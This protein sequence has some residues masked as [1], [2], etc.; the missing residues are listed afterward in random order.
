MNHSIAHAMLFS[1]ILGGATALAQEFPFQHT[2]EVYRSDEDETIA[3]SLRL[4]QPFLAE[5]FEKSNYL[6]LRSSDPN[7]YLIY[8][9]ETKFYQ[10]HAEF[11]GRLKGS[12]KV[13][14]QLSYE[15]VSEN[16]DGSRRVQVREGAITLAIPD[17]PADRKSVG[18]RSIFED[19]AR[20]QNEHFAR[21]LTYY[22]DESF[23]QYCLLQSKARY[24][25]D[26][27]A[28][29]KR[30]PTQDNL[31]DGLYK[32]FTG[33]LAIQESLQR[34]TLS[35]SASRG[36][37]TRHISE[38]SPPR[39]RSLD[40]EELLKQRLDKEKDVTVQV[41]E[42][43]KLVPSDQ[44]FL[45]FNSFASLGEA[46]DLATQWGDD[47]VRLSKLTAQDNRL[48]AKLEE[49]L[50]IS[51]SGMEELFAQSVATEVA[52]TGSDPY[53]LDG[54]DVTV[55]I[56][57]KD[58]QAFAKQ[59]NSWVDEERGR[60]PDLVQRDFNYRGHQ[61]TARYTSDRLVSA[62]TTRHDDYYVFSN[63][64]RAIRRIVDASLGEVDRLHDAADYRYISTLMP[65]STDANSG[66]YFASDAFIRRIVA[67][68]AKISQKRRVECFNNLVMQNN[69]SL[70]FRLEYG[71]SPNSLSEMI[72]KRFIAADRITCPH[73]GA[74]AFDANSD[75]CT[76]SLHNR[77]RYLTPNAELSVLK[78]SDEE[79]AEYG[80]YKTRYQSFW[81][82]VFDP[83]ATRIT[84]APTMKLETCVLPMSGSTYYQDLRGLVDQ[85]PQP[86]D[87]STI[88]PS[89]V[90]SM[91]MVPGRKNTA[92]YLM[93]I[94]GVSDVVTEDPTL[95]DLQWL[96][97]R[98]SLHVC[99]GEIIFEI[100][101]TLLSP[102]Q[103]PIVGEAPA[104]W[105]ALAGGLILTANM[106]VYATIDVE[107][108]EKAERLLE[109]FSQKAFLKGG[110]VGPLP[111]KFDAY[112]LPDYRDHEMYVFSARLHAVALRL[113][114]ALVNDQ[115]VLATKPEI[116][117]EVIDASSN[118]SSQEPSQ[119]QLMFRLNR[120]ALN[121]LQ[122]DVHLHW[123]EKS[124]LACHRNIISIHNFYQLYDAPIDQIAK[125]SEAKYGIR[126]FCP[127]DGEYSFDEGSSQVVCSVHGNR[128]SSR[129]NPGLN[130]NSS[131]AKLIESIDQIIVYLRYE[132][133]AM[134]ATVEIDRNET[135]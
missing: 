31:E 116:L 61:V 11:H 56:R 134:I 13:D 131:S 129:Q 38:I 2:V 4:E 69:A 79:A 100:D 5:E 71:R 12:G 114:I 91:V 49:Q 101:P 72:E 23:F 81:Q 21:L 42:I 16:L 64:H 1:W 82:K 95:T 73:G 98:V 93:A 75:T 130:P 26:P 17:V 25:V 43:S 37:Y 39:I 65:P 53:L 45:H 111:S 9:K 70:F 133:E 102:I 119:A 20:Q 123:A 52:V 126:Y 77:L 78:V 18:P 47:L 48:V 127:E 122:D 118:V 44:Y 124:R 7:A 128:E 34:R 106:P 108:N 57:V 88:A 6:R 125:L 51:R 3:F 89:A 115:L 97:D 58:E 109:Q 32:L 96:G 62:F 24:G 60:H 33:S 68:A 112:R 50:G 80:R 66:Y 94:P 10:K 85:N 120:Q 30:M 36:A 15:T 8:P 107:N 113:H 84:V 135:P 59:L 121:K 40:Y 110:Q 117:R 41:H 35:S 103:L 28:I 105:Q 19:W 99:D 86:I 54:T 132:Q 74:Y 76:C 27:P 22:P 55:I 67:P 83:V 63:S 46:V 92:Q 87:V 14:V 29:P 90:A 104:M